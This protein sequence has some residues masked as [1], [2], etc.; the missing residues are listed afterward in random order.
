MLAV[1]LWD[2]HVLAV[3]LLE[4]QVPQVLPQVQLHLVPA[5]FHL[6][7]NRLQHDH[8][9]HVQVQVQEAEEGRDN[10]QSEEAEEQEVRE[11]LDAE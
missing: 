6:P 10:L 2:L 1:L 9:R 11:D 5:V 4:L 7:R 3:L 8:P